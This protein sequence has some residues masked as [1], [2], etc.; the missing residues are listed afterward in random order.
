MADQLQLRGGT[1]A[2]TAAFTG[3]L[4]EVTVDT[5]K[6]TLVVHDGALAGGYPL[7]REDSSNSA[8]AL[9][10]AATPSLKFTGDTNTG[11]YSPGADQVGISTGGTGR[12]FIDASGRVGIGTSTFSY[13][14]N[15]LVIDK[16]STGNDGIT[17]VS[18]NTSNASIWFAD[19]TTGS[20]A[21]RG[22]ID[23]NHS[24]DKMQ[25]YTGA[26][27]NITID[28]AG[29]LGIG[30]TTVMTP[31]HVKLATD[32]NVGFDLDGSNEARI[33]A[34]NDAYTTN[35][36]LCINGE[37]LRFQVQGGEKARID[38]S[39]R[40]G[41]GTSTPAYTLVAKG[42]VATTGIVSSIINPVSGGNS[43]IHFTDE[44]TYNWTAGTVGNAF[45]ITPSEASTSSGTPALYINSSGNVGIGTTS[46]G[47]YGK[48]AVFGAASNAGQ[49]ISGFFYN[50]DAASSTICIQDSTSASGGGIGSVGNNLVLY[51]NSGVNLAERARI[52]SNGRLLVGTSSARSNLYNNSSGVA[53]QI[54]LEG[55]SFVTSSMM[56]V[57]N[58][59]DNNDT[60]IILGKT[61][62][63]SPG[64][65]TLVSNGD[66]V[67]SISFQGADGSE[68]VELASIQAIIDGTPGANNMP[69]RIVLST[70][71]AG[72]SSPTERMRIT[73]LGVPRFFS[74]DSG[75]I[76]AISAGSA[77]NENIFVGSHSA[78]STTSGTNCILI[79]ANGDVRNTN[80]SYGAISDV[81]LKENIVDASSQ[82]DDLKALQ[83]RKYNLKAETGQQTH[84]QI[85]LV[86]QEVELVSP[87]LV[88]ESPD[89]D[90]EG[91]DL[92]TVTKSV[93][94][95]VL[96]MK[97]V[98]AL[99]EAMERIETLEGMVAVNNITIDEQQHQLSTL[100]AR[101]TALESA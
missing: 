49:N 92:G 1:T 98:K 60:S 36:P 72:S 86:A 12:L 100:A 28:S 63:T 45:A 96:Y 88:S 77:T 73:N 21:Y 90:E 22:G 10:S 40:L 52:D 89:R 82:W 78:T 97:A 66:G 65:N 18:S 3:A 44:A 42:G 8:L 54:Q 20:E 48:L 67:G 26:Q 41:I 34:F 5:D 99:Q 38:S 24:T 83:V 80:N 13:L 32:K 9:G 61:R 93:N 35:I 30:A 68:L 15:K 81:K 59:A 55:T 85:G 64:A 6:D 53:P 27:G 57:R 47:G 101:L 46:P 71:A 75:L 37:D 29:H 79:K 19:G 91:N 16:G 94:Y 11:I 2:Q 76:S 50:P 33:L 43:K 14:A 58:S 51:S 17:I 84:T 62:G 25:I 70:T 69:G 74:S 23:Y 7:M 56:L 95:S 87:G 39:G 4:R 31:L